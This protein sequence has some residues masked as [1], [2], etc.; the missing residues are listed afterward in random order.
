VVEGETQGAGAGRAGQVWAIDVSRQKSFREIFSRA[1]C[2]HTPHHT[3]K[4]R[5]PPPTPSKPTPNEPESALTMANSKAAT[6]QLQNKLHLP[7][8]AAIRELLIQQDVD[9]GGSISCQNQLY[10]DMAAV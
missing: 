8:T 2:R 10:E 7:S 4:G 9:T 6:L 5:H 3:Q 1:F